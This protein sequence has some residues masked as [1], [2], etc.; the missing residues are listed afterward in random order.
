MQN[1]FFFSF[2]DV[3]AAKDKEINSLKELEKSLRAEQSK[4][5]VSLKQTNVLSLEMDA[6]EKSLKETTQKLEAMNVQTVEV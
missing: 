3:M 1:L 5:K 6:Y 4:I 2:S